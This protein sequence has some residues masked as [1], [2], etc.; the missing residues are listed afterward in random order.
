MVYWVNSHKLSKQYLKDTGG[1]GSSLIGL[2][3]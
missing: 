2:Q 3:G 1:G